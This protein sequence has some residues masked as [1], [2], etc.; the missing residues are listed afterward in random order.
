MYISIQFHF[1]GPRQDCDHAGRKPGRS[2]VLL[3]TLWVGR[4]LLSSVS[5][6]LPDVTINPV[7]LGTRNHV[8]RE[9]AAVT[10]SKPVAVVESSGVLLA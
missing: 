2:Y 10:P 1:V 4:T 9:A 7:Y 3:N 5:I 8:P 6:D